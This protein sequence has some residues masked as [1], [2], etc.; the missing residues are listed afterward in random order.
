[1]RAAAESAAPCCYQ[2]TSTVS[3]HSTP[4]TP[5]PCT[6]SPPATPQD[7]GAAYQILSDPEKRE[8]Y[9]RLGAAG[10]SDAPIM[11]AGA[12]FGVLFGSDVFEEYVGERQSGVGL[13]NGTECPTVSAQYSP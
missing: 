6:P 3:L 2:L 1:M 7:L 4:H 5:P 11:D 10:V 8:L 12:M 9:D 13:A